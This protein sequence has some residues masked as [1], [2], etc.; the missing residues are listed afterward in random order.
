M[1]RVL[2]G[3]SGG[4]AAYKACELCRLLVREGHDVVPLVTPGAERF[5]TEE[6]FR[7]LARRPPGDDVYLHLTRADLLVV[8]PCTANTLAKLAHGIA[9]N[10][11]T[12]AALAHRGPV[13]IAPAMNPRMWAHPATRANAETL[14]ARGVV[15]VG[16][17]EGETA[18]GELGVGRMAEPAEIFRAA[19]DILLGTGPLR[20]K[21]VLVSAGGTREPLDAVRFVG[22]RSSGRMGVALAAEARRRGAEVTLLGANLAVPPASGV[23]LVETPTAAD[24]ERE[25]LVRAAE[26]DVVVMAAAVADY[27]PAEAL[28]AK[29][30]KDTATW[31]LELEPT[32]DVL[33]ALG[34]R[35]RDDQLL[36][37]FAAE[38]GAN[39]L[40]RAREKLDRKGADLFVL[41][42]VSRTDIGFDTDENE[43]TL[44][45][46]GGERTV[47][48]APKDEI[49]AA[50][51]DEVEALLAD[52]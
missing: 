20:G 35:R 49:A 51:L 34:E 2:L 23:E 52:G 29:R 26:A 36:V 32:T 24:L 19:Q 48:K 13:L 14:R 44:L 10:V 15:L 30:P 5:V 17:D 21:R 6:T 12:E 11:L 25:A 46:A 50:I 22:N 37:G 31:T 8:A 38:T 42:D 7:A 16:P 4:I 27:R 47:P 18:E 39:G 45:T 28:A 43:V 33:A 3:V 9:D 1:G 40:E 41:N